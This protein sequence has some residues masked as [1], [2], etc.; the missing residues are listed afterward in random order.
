MAVKMQKVVPPTG[1]DVTVRQPIGH[2]EFN[3]ES[4]ETPDE[5]AFKLIARHSDEGVFEFPGPAE[6][7]VIR[8]TV[9]YQS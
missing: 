9:E 6:D 2:V 4:G 1:F 7:Q 8:V 3:N 5:A